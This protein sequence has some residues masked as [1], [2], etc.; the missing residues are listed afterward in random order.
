MA[1]LKID[2]RRAMV[3]TAALA[4]FMTYGYKRTTMDDIAKAAGLSR[5]ALYLLYRNKADVFGACL[6]IKM[7]EM[8][9]KVAGCFNG[10]G[11]VSREVEA[12][13]VEGILRPHEEIAG[14]P[15]GAELFDVKH[16]F[17]GDLF[18]AW[19]SAV[20]EEIASGLLAAAKAGRIGAAAGDVS[21]QE[22]ASILLDAVEGMKMRT[23]GIDVLSRKLPV[24]VRMLIAP[25]ET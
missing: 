17:A 15:H 22:I 19:M 1:E 24:L 9:E 16:E 12:A 13:L 23:P 20:E 18:L 14:T 5:P 10:R 4:T 2:H 11:S 6:E 3:L 21:L 7:E 8:R 25:L